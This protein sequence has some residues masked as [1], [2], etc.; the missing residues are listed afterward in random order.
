[1][2]SCK[3][4]LMALLLAVLVQKTVIGTV[5]TQISLIPEGVCVPLGHP[6]VLYCT[7]QSASNS[8]TRLLFYKGS[9][10]IDTNLT[11][12]ITF[13]PRCLRRG[14]KCKW[15]LTAS[16]TVDPA[17]ESDEGVYW[18]KAVEDGEHFNASAE[19]FVQYQSEFEL[20]DSVM[21]VKLGEKVKV[22]LDRKCD[23][24]EPVQVTR[25]GR[26]RVI[27]KLPYRYGHEESQSAYVDKL[28][29]A[30]VIPNFQCT[31]EG[32]YSVTVMAGR[33]FEPVFTSRFIYIKA[34]CEGCCPEE[35]TVAPTRKSTANTQAETTAIP[36]VIE[37]LGG[38]ENNTAYIVVI[39]VLAVSA[40]AGFV[41]MIL[42][43]RREIRDLTRAYNTRAHAD[44]KGETDRLDVDV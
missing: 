22:K 3:F 19:V 17:S 4:P 26:G 37:K 8:D 27:E 31:D 25:T 44:A 2:D 38:A 23:K 15:D 11:Q 1:M 18:C 14:S 43:Y 41:V 16:L 10:P 5:A 7:L 33:G 9:M 28:E 32:N 29:G 6:I 12:V 39:V 20:P 30:L 42:Y 24:L 13:P 34:S 35:A 40:I 36:G 21:A